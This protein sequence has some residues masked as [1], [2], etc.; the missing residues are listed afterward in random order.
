[1]STPPGD[2]PGLLEVLAQVRDPR[3]FRGRRYRLVF[4]LAVAAACVLAGARSFREIGGQADLPQDVLARLGG[5]MHPLRRKIIAP[6]EKRIRTLIHAMGAKTA[7]SSCSPPCC[8]RKGHDRPAPIPD[9]TTETTQVKE[10]LDHVDLENAV[11]TADAA[12]TVGLPRIL[13]GP[14]AETAGRTASPV[15]L[16]C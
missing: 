5:V 2:V 4:V 11:V 13:T 6:S 15:H 8:T 16:H 9:E 3:R 14:S 7:R 12:V 1:M 10:L